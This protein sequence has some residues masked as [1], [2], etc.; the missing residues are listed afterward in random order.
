MKIKHKPT[1][2]IAGGKLE[3][4]P[5]DNWV[6]QWDDEAG[7]WRPILYAPDAETVDLEMI[8]KAETAYDRLIRLILGNP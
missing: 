5:T 6:V 7:V 2:N 8:A 4:E 1:S 3:I